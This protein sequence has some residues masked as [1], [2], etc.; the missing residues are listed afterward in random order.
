MTTYTSARQLANDLHRHLG[1]NGN[2]KEL[3]P[4]PIHGDTSKSP[5]LSIDASA[6][7]ER[8]LLNCFVCE[9]SRKTELMGWLCDKG[10]VMEKYLPRGERPTREPLHNGNDTVQPVSV[11]KQVWPCRN[12]I[13][14]TIH[15]HTRIDKSDGSKAVFWPKNAGVR[16]DEMIYQAFGYDPDAYYDITSIVVTEGEKAAD[17]IQ[18]LDDYDAIATVCGASTLPNYET[19]AATLTQVGRRGLTTVY[20]W[21]DNDPPGLSHML[22]VAALFKAAIKELALDVK[23]R[24]VAPVV[25]EGVKGAD[26]A[27]ITAEQSKMCIASAGEIPH[28]GYDLPE[29]DEQSGGNFHVVS[30]TE[31]HVMGDDLLNRTNPDELPP[32]YE[33]QEIHPKVEVITSAS[34]QEGD[35]PVDQEL[36]LKLTVA[37]RNLHQ[38]TLGMFRR[39]DGRTCYRPKEGKRFANRLVNMDSPDDH[40]AKHMEVISF[41]KT[42]MH[43]KNGLIVEESALGKRYEEVLVRH[44]PRWSMGLRQLGASDRTFTP[45]FNSR[46]QFIWLPG[47]YDPEAQQIHL[48]DAEDFNPPDPTPEGL[49]KASKYVNAV[50]AGFPFQSNT[51]LGAAVGMLISAAFRS[52]W[53]DKM[54]LNL[55]F[56]RERG[57]GKSVFCNLLLKLANGPHGKLDFRLSAQAKDHELN[58]GMA[59]ALAQE[60]SV[61][62]FDNFNQGSRSDTVSQLITGDVMLRKVGEGDLH[63]KQPKCMF[64]LNGAGAGACASQDHQ[65]RAITVR[66]AGHP[67]ANLNKYSWDFGLEFESDAEQAKMNLKALTAALATIVHHFFASGAKPAEPMLSD[68]IGWQDTV[69]AIVEWAGW[70]NPGKSQILEMGTGDTELNALMAFLEGIQSSVFGGKGWVAEDM[71]KEIVNDEHYRLADEL[72]TDADLPGLGRGNLMDTTA[73][74]FFRALR[75]AINDR[76]SRFRLPDSKSVRIGGRIQRL[77]QIFPS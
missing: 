27:D 31:L 67:D 29:A 1:G 35:D 28:K 57:A 54:P 16:T 26:A 8:L 42:R 22:G 36:R 77:N 6:D 56:S 72:F 68:F 10:F 24:W 65:R 71:L 12:P 14:G 41:R 37:V 66:L 11:K 63:G 18:Q 7:D 62:L 58:Y 33:P 64:I 55:V 75:K 76:A 47:E 74:W 44:S 39:H 50:L 13:T 48:Y 25:I 59:D 38:E 30:R 51:H 15:Q 43:P 60:K 45:T 52:S 4:C 69:A 17:A 34:M 46:G 61:F 32:V 49:V 53:P 40:F 21:P 70:V 9:G 5:N 73:P 23:M 19:I 3:V 20:I 2:L